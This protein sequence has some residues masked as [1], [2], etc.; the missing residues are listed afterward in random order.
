MNKCKKCGSNEFL[1][2][3]SDIYKASIDKET[4]IL[5]C[6]KHYG[7]GYDKVECA[8][9]GCEYNIDDFKEIQINF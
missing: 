4:N 1:V 3:E 2:F 8:K 7:G 6:Y 9:C 5:E